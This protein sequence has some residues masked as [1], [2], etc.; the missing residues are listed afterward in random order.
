MIRDGIVLACKPP[1]M[2][3]AALVSI[4]K[5]KTG[6]KAGHTGTLDR[7]AEGLMILLTGRATGF[8]DHFLKL[9]KTYEATIR[10]GRSTD[11]L[12]PHGA[13]LDEWPTAKVQAF[14]EAE[15]VRIEAAVSAMTSVTSQIPPAYSA[16]KQ[17]GLRLSDRMRRG[18]ETEVRARSIRIYAARC[19]ELRP[20]EGLLRAFF[21][22]SSGTYIRSIARDLGESLGIPASLDRLKRLSIGDLSLDHPL[23]WANI[24]LGDPPIIGLLEAFPSWPR[25]VVPAGQERLVANGG[26][27]A[28]PAGMPEG[29]VFLVSEGGTLL[30]WATLDAAGMHYR[31]VLSGPSAV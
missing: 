20:A 26:R 21:S 29:D 28:V 9:D 4:L 23:L 31:K 14:M 24:E 8:A 5:R 13:V 19:L 22:V 17:N 18:L 6:L 15:H 12:D 30:A 25:M 3:S 16:L 7:F 27:L 1:E 11:T 10:L 2:G